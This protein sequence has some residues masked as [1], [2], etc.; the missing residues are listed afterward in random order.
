M[1]YIEK[2]HVDGRDNLKKF[3]IDLKPTHGKPFKHLILIGSSGSGKSTTLDDVLGQFY[4]NKKIDAA[5]SDR[6]LIVFSR[7]EIDPNSYMLR[8]NYNHYKER[9][10]GCAEI[11]SD[12]I[13]KILTLPSGPFVH[14]IKRKII[15]LMDVV[16]IKSSHGD[17]FVHPDGYTFFPLTMGSGHRA[18]AGIF[19]EITLRIMEC[20]KYRHDVLHDPKSYEEDA[21]FDPEGIVIIDD[22]DKNLRPSIQRKI[23]PLLTKFFPKIQFLVSTHSPLVMSSIPNALVVDLDKRGKDEELSDDIQGIRYGTLLTSLLGLSADFDLDSEDLLE[24]LKSLN[25]K[26]NRTSQEDVELEKLASRLSRRSHTM[27]TSV[28]AE[29]QS[30]KLEESLAQAKKPK[31]KGRV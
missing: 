25:A 18:I 29:L 8:H 2:V 9:D 14:D 12:R 24:R 22:I 19:S 13:A 15:E 28:W 31:K 23:L 4:H 30:K 5:I 10:I 7:N 20:R 26:T 16:G 6:N 27:A 3:T 11:D 21:S 17:H 1:P